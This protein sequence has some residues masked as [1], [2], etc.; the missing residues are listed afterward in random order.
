MPKRLRLELYSH[1]ARPHPYLAVTLSM[2]A[3]M[4]SCSSAHPG[5]AL[6]AG[7]VPLRPGRDVAGPHVH[8]ARACRPFPGVT[9]SGGSTTSAERAM[10][11]NGTSSAPGAHDVRRRR[12]GGPR[13]C[14]RSRA[15]AS[16]G[17][18]RPRRRSPAPGRAG[19]RRRSSRGAGHGG[20]HRPWRTPGT[21]GAGT[22][23]GAK[24]ERDPRWRT[25]GVGPPGTAM[26]GTS[27][28]RPAQGA[29]QVA[30][31]PGRRGSTPRPPP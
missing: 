20:R 24:L 6:D 21:V 13:R 29:A 12:A 15:G 4:P 16:H 1:M 8:R 14:G 27:R 23:W 30:P 18:T 19:P 10:A 7:V 17:S 26:A 11:T 9:S 28:R 31:S 25:P 2:V 3:T 5:L 22:T